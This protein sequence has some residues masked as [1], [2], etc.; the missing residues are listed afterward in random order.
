MAADAYDTCSWPMLVKPYCS[1]P[2]ITQAQF[3]AKTSSLS[4][5]FPA[6]ASNPWDL[7]APDFF[8]RAAACVASVGGCERAAVAQQQWQAAFGSNVLR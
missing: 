1:V 3:L 2:N 8:E 5:V 7:S 4:K 6:G